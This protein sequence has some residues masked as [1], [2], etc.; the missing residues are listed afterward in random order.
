MSAP[1][2]GVRLARLQA[3]D[4]AFWTESQR[5]AFELA[6]QLSGVPP[7]KAGAES[8]RG[9]RGVAFAAWRGVSRSRRK[10]MLREVTP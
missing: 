10:A 5:R 1:E 4:P 9:Q 8:W 6:C 3:R 7:T 2:P